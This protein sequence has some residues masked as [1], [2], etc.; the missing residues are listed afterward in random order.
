MTDAPG[1]ADRL[2]PVPCALCRGTE[3]TLVCEKF[4]LPIAR[5]TTCGLVRATPR[6]APERIA[7]RYSAEYFW[8][9]Y[10]PSLGVV[11]GQVD[12]RF[13]DE[14]YAPW[15]QLVASAVGPAGRLLEIGSGAGLFAKAFARAGW[16]VTGVEINPEGAQFARE[17]LGVDVRSQYAEDLDVAPGTM[18]VVA[19]M[20]VIEHV[21]DPAATVATARRFLRPGGALLIQ[22][23][24]LDALS[25]HTLGTPW[26][27][28]STAEHLYYFTEGTLTALLTGAGFTSVTFEWTFA[29]F[30][31]AETMNARYTHA[32]AA[33][34]ARAYAA[35]V[36]VG[37]AALLRWVRSAH[38]TD[39][40]IAVARA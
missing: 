20:D 36:R 23:P 1:A 24:N 25:R 18:D 39:Q 14:R 21:P 9:E 7:A 32:P 10:L 6:C 38:L 8:G 31:P 17:R 29:G 4:G 5:C 2:T 28:L 35:A 34:R 27:V 40:L 19:M 3:T 22:T 33:L 12:E 15:V 11:N 30:G 16:T 37:G 13:I 26:A